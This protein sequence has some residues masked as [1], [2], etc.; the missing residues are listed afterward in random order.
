MSVL[1]AYG[2]DIVNLKRPQSYNQ[3]F[4]KTDNFGPSYLEVLEDAYPKIENDSIRFLVLN[5]LA[6]YWHT[7]DL[8]KALDFARI[9]LGLT[10]DA[11][12]LHWEG[13]FQ[14]TEAAILLRMEKLDSAYTI[15]QEAKS[16]VFKKDLPILTAQLGYVFERKGELVRA[17]DYALEAKRLAED[18]ND[19]RAIAVSYS[20]LSNLFWKHSKFDKGLEYGLKSI[21]YFE[22]RGINDMDYDFALYVVGNNLLELQRYEEALEYFNHAIAM[23]ERYGF[24]NN[25]SDAYISLVELYTF[26]NQYEEAE[27]AGQKAIKYAKLLNN[28]FLL[29]RSWLSI[30]KLKLFQGK[31]ITAIDNLKKSI[32][33]AGPDF[34]DKYYLSQ[35]FEYLG[36]AYVGNHN[37]KG[38]TESFAVYDSL[39][40]QMF[41]EASDQ[42]ISLLQTEFEI[43]QKESTIQ[44]MENQLKRQSSQKTLISIIA[45]LLLMLLV[46]LYVT[47]Q[48]DKGK[49]IL[50]ERQNK[51]K[52]FLLKEIHHRVK[53]NLGIVS[54]LLDLQAAKMKD[55]NAIEAI[56]ESRN[57]VYSMSMIHQKLYQGKNLSS[58][59]MKDYFINLSKHILDS[60][61]AEKLI[62]FDYELDHVELDVDF[63]IPLGLIVNELLTNSFKHAFPN[64]EK[65]YIKIIFQKKAREK[66]VLEIIDDGIG[67]HHNVED[68][69]GTG[70]GTLLIDLLVK[71]L[72]GTLSIFNERGTRVRMEFGANSRMNDVN[73]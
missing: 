44:G 6:Y 1:S 52:E 12:N 37:Y 23:G 53:N 49:S 45:G 26:L 66:F 20:D 3:I 70:F 15:L 31:Y 4:V 9:G 67:S 73:F 56:E 55:P 7:R 30:G 39:K 51:E 43:A 34:G 29:M 61:G 28:N 72:D 58:I 33:I 24:Y 40:N 35:A 18:L 11:E 64:G 27:K 63:A 60:Y 48:K 71:Q 57:R 42:R 13:R 17:A 65:G 50:L 41:T 22:E 68:H 2:Q 59:E 62:E 54:S 32:E 38:G 10:R 46:V 5:D 36:K 69:S 47:Y 16:K 14:I 8:N 21:K 19:V 25:L